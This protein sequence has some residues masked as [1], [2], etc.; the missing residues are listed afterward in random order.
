MADLKKM[1]MTQS[2]AG[3]MGATSTSA[4]NATGTQKAVSMRGAG[5]QKTVLQVRKLQDAPTRLLKEKDIIEIYDSLCQ[6][7]KDQCD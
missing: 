3:M 7:C 5:T 4:M 1:G 2:S 6:R